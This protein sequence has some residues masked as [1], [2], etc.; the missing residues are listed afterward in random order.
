VSIKLSFLFLLFILLA[1]CTKEEYDTKPKL[2]FKDLKILSLNEGL[3]SIL[4][5]NLEVLD[6]EGDVKDSIY[7]AN[8]RLAPSNCIDTLPLFNR[9]PDFP[10]GNTQKVLFRLQ[11][12]TDGVEGFNGD[13]RLPLKCSNNDVNI[14]RIAVKDLAGN[15]SDTL[16][17]PSFTI[18]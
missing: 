10:I 6:K 17:T 16:T 13:Q 1:G 5:V 15:V 4:E 3:G 8:I 12:A 14:L 11:F 9:I 18:P 7:I 2:I